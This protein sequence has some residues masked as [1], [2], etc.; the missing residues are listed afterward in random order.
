MKK[1]KTN[2]KILVLFLSMIFIGGIIT[3]NVLFTTLTGIHLRSGTNVL[4]AKSNFQQVTSTI[5]AKRGLI[6]DRDGETI[7]QNRETYTIVAVLSEEREGDYAY[8]ADKEFTAKALAPILGMSEEKILNYLNQ[9]VYQTYLGDKG[10]NLTLDQKKAIDAIVYTPDKTKPEKTIN[11]LPGIEFEKTVTRVYTPGKFS[12]TLLGFASY[13]SESKRIVGQVGI[14]AYLDEKL[15]GKDGKAIAKKDGKGYTIPGT[16]Q[17]IETET[18]GNDVYLTIDKDVQEALE[19]ALQKTVDEIGAKNAWAIV[20]EVETGKILGYGGYPTYDLNERDEVLYFDM[21]SMFTFEPGSVM[22]PFT[23]AIA[24]EEGVYDGDAKVKTGKFCVAYNDDYTEIYRKDGDCSVSGNI[25]DANRKGWGSITMDEGLL[26]SSNT[27]IATILTE[28]LKTDVFWEY[29]DKLGFFKPTGTEGLEMSEEMGLKNNTYAIDKVTFGFG[30]GSSVTA[31]QLMQAYTAILN[32]G[33]EVKPYY[34]DKIVDA[35]NNIVYE[36]ST[37][38]VHTDEDNNPVRVFSS[39]TC[40]QVMELMK[41]VIQDTS[42]GTGSGYNI[43]G[44]D[45][46]GK[47]GTGEIFSAGGYEDDL[48]TSSI[49]AAAPSDDPKVMVYYA[50]QSPYVGT[51]DK[52][53]FKSLFTAAYEAVGIKQTDTSDKDTNYENWQEYEMPSLKNHTMDYANQKLKDLDI[54]KIIIGNGNM[55][56]D[57][58]PNSNDLV[59]TNQNVFIKT[60]STNITLPNMIKWSYKDVMIYKELS[61]LNITCVGSGVVKSQSVAAKTSVTSETEII[62][63]LE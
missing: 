60:N 63:T 35:S 25:N 41:G 5:T 11:G 57:Q 40:Q 34:I 3:F 20:M 28:Y 51:F 56:I 22:K 18:N 21:P 38:Y 23:Y 6:K 1:N 14:E 16:Y 52:S 7:A 26:R 13:D 37:T 44:F 62:V 43:E 27:V 39:E 8:V 58:Y 17:I 15:T 59:S 9:D 49:M 47:T 4:E 42:K 36:G 45:M 2:I 30:Q 32:D 55:V 50:F 31:L 46:I 12:S 54:H 48:Y 53:Y 61:G 33:Y 24:M 29:I 10:K 19:D